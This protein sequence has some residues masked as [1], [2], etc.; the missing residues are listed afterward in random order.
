MTM[1]KSVLIV[2]D[3]ASIRRA[4]HQVFGSEADFDVCG[5]AEN[6]REAIAKAQELHPDLIVLD[7]SMPEMNGIDAAR[8]LKRL[9]PS[10]PLIV[11]S[12]YSDVFTAEEAHSIGISALVSKT[13]HVSH[14]VGKARALLQPMAA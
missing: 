1:T 14:L 8:T 6:G 13:E 10:V 12:G 2:D 11:F 3:T 4:L 9:M 5:E 7:L